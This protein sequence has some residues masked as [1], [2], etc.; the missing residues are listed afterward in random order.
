MHSRPPTVGARQCAG[1]Q[2]GPSARFTCPDGV[3]SR[4][5]R[6]AYHPDSPPVRVASRT[7]ARV[8]ASH[9][10]ACA[11]V[12]QSISRCLPAFR[13]GAC[14]KVWKWVTAPNRTERKRACRAACVVRSQGAAAHG[15]LGTA[16]P[17]R[18]RLGSFRADRPQEGRG[19]SH[20][21]RLCQVRP[22]LLRKSP[23]GARCVA[24]RSGERRAVA[25]RGQCVVS[26]HRKQKRRKARKPRR[27]WFEG[28]GR[29]KDRT[30]DPY[31]VKV[32]LYR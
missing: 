27:C 29:Y 16:A 11:G 20:N 12:N 23:Q 19:G 10:D 21:G 8:S 1:S 31:H 5:R 25:S 24:D 22:V 9:Y 13:A 30:C 28:G 26:P 7:A 32:V 6:R 4:V 3:R 2:A 17:R 14:R 15:R 18:A